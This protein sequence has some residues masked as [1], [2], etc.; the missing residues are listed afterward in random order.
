MIKKQEK[1]EREIAELKEQNA[2]L[3]WENRQLNE[4]L[5]YFL[6][7]LFSKKSEQLDPRQLELSLD[8]SA[9]NTADKPEEPPP[10]KSTSKSRKKRKS[11]KERL[12]EN[13]PVEEVVIEPD[14]VKKDPEA[15]RYIGQEATDELNV[16][17]TRFYIVRTIRPKY[18]KIADRSVAPVVAPAPVRLIDK[19]RPNVAKTA[20]FFSS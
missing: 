7:Q 16:L 6:R 8:L 2:H 12:P 20:G 19:L 15:Y 3:Q 9:S 1:L 17:A 5:R 18:V 4:K 10:E 14:E 13:L 11:R